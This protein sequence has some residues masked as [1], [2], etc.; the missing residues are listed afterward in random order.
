LE[1]NHL[2]FLNSFLEGRNQNGEATVDRAVERTALRGTANLY[3]PT[4]RLGKEEDSVYLTLSGT[5][6]GTAVVGEIG[7]FEE[8]TAAFGP[9]GRELPEPV[10]DWPTIEEYRAGFSLLTADLF[11][12]RDPLAG[13]GEEAGF[14]RALLGP[15]EAYRHWNETEAAE[16]WGT[17][18][19]EA[20][21]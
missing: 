12:P 2:D 1:R 17:R 10:F 5:E 8:F 7:S 21:R 15:G 19:E 11:E 14:D 20:G 9:T 4:G 6:G 13:S 18:F 16:A 3:R